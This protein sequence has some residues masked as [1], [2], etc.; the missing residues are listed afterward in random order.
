MA[1]PAWTVGRDVAAEKKTKQKKK[2]KKKERSPTT[3]WRWPC[4]TC[5]SFSGKTPFNGVAWRAFGGKNPMET[6]KETGK[7]R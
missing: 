7:T 1:V 6:S 3:T 4:R 2:K 5:M